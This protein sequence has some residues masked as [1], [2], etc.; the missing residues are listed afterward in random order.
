MVVVWV[1]AVIVVVV[2]APCPAH[3]VIA[4]HILVPILISRVV[5]TLREPLGK[6]YSTGFVVDGKGS[7]S[8][9]PCH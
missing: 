3:S 4:R 2:Y 9:L 7:G 1:A 8:A 5:A 6:E